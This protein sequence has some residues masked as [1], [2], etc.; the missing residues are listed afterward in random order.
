MHG[1]EIFGPGSF[2]MQGGMKKGVYGITWPS[3]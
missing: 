2:V 3:A 1:A